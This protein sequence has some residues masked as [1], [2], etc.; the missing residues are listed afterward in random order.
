MTKYY[1][2]LEDLVIG[3]I[4]AWVYQFDIGVPFKLYDIE[5]AVLYLHKTFYPDYTPSST[6]A[7]TKTIS[8]NLFC[9][10]LAP[11]YKHMFIGYAY[12]DSEES[13]ERVCADFWR[14]FLFV[15]NTSYDKYAKLIELNESIKDNLMDS[16]HSSTEN[17]FNDTPQNVQGEYDW[18][19]DDHLTNVQRASV[20]TDGATKIARLD[21]VQKLLKDFYDEWAKEFER[22]FIFD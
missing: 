14:K 15:L 1:Y 19:T 6:E 3:Q 9:T 8:N 20:D 21:E 12:D 10:N 2:T 11:Q 5:D 22:L 4:G 16:I 18:S 7:I 13:R 17:K